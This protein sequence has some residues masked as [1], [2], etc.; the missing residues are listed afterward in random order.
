MRSNFVRALVGTYLYPITDRQLSGLSHAEQVAKLSGGGAT[1]I[2]LREK[3]ASPL[4]FY[5]EAEAALQVARERGVKII[6]NDRVDIALA[7][8]ADGVHLGQ[9]DL[10]PAAARRILGPNA[11]IGF[12]THNLE[13]ARLARQQ[14]V[15]YIAIGPVFATSTKQSSNSP[16]GLKELALV[17][18]SLG[19]IPLVAIGGISVESLGAVLKAGADAVAVISGIWGFGTNA[20]T[21]RPLNFS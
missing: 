17:R 20:P 8:K 10:A 19:G 7:L 16:I 9:E 4:E 13:Q 21:K 11:I 2:Q 5:Q 14:P 12:S 3:S 18:R 1:L 15:D 6:I